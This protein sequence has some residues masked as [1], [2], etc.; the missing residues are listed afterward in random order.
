MDT[1]WLISSQIRDIYDQ[2]YV[3]LNSEY[4]PDSNVI[5]DQLKQLNQ[6]DAHHKLVELIFEIDRIYPTLEMARDSINR[7]K[8]IWL[9]KNLETLRTQLK[10]NENK[11]EDSTELINKITEVQ[12]QINSIKG[13]NSV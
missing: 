11:F 6:K 10:D 4:E 13:I 8:Y 5:L 1:S 9:K 3:H 7:L 12:G 2:L